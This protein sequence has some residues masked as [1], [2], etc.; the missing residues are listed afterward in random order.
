MGSYATM[1][2]KGQLTIPKEVRDELKLSAGTRLHITVQ[3]GALI[4][5]PKNKKVEDIFG[6]IKVPPGTPA[7]TLEDYDDAIGEALAQDDRRIVR[8]WNELKR[9]KK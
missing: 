3:D 1:T 5:R 8:E 4:G 2:S 6:M 9:T 7:A